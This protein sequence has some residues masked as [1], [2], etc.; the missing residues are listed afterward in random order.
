MRQIPSNQFVLEALHRE[1][2]DLEKTL[3]MYDNNPH[4]LKLQEEH[5]EAY[6]EAYKEFLVNVLAVIKAVQN[7]DY[8]VEESALSNLPSIQEE[9]AVFYESEL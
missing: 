6:K 8:P 7:L 5:Q 1:K 4:F 2:E 3:E 9:L